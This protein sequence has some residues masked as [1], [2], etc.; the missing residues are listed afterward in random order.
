MSGFE[1]A[2]FSYQNTIR[3][4]FNMKRKD[5]FNITNNLFV[6]LSWELIPIVPP[7]V[8]PRSPVPKTGMIAITPRNLKNGESY[9]QSYT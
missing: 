2:K 4:I 6:L 7:G 1:P 5:L 9:P 3:G 8:E